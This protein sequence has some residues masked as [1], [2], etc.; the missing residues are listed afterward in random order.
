MDFGVYKHHYTVPARYMLEVAFYN[1]VG[2]A[3]CIT[4]DVLVLAAPSDSILPFKSCQKA[5]MKIPKLQFESIEGGHFEVYDG[6]KYFEGNVS[7]QV[8]FLQSKALT[9]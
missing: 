9:C 1:P 4:A 5:T 2:K 8:A 3:E 7:K 6:G